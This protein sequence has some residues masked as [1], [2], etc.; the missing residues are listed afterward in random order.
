L[1]LW[2]GGGFWVAE[3][4][5]SLGRS[6]LN[7]RGCLLLLSGGRSEVETKMRFA[8][9]VVAVRGLGGCC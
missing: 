1:G 5:R 3:G 7:Q 8:V 2:M 4:K 6:Y 9:K